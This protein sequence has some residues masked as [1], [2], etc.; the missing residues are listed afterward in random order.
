MKEW[1]VPREVVTFVECR[2]CDYKGTKMQENQGQGFLSKEQLCNMW[3]GGCKEVWN[4]RDQEAESRRAEKVKCGTYRG[5][6]SVIWKV[7]R[8]T[9]GEIFCP[10]CRT[11]KKTPWWNWGRKLEWPVPRAQVEG[12]GIIDPE[13]R[14]REVKRTLKGLWKVWM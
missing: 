3:C 10:P 4:W 11:R 8:N 6:D 2:G 7:K 12:A 14:Q 5:K 1:T 13:K 9:K